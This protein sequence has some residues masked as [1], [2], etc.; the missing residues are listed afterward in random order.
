MRYQ[1]RKDDECEERSFLF[2]VKS[3]FALVPTR[4]PLNGREDRLQKN[5]KIRAWSCR[6]HHDNALQKG[7]AIKLNSVE[8]KIVRT[9]AKH[10]IKGV[11]P[12]GYQLL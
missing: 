12:W 8:I 2:T 11:F 5:V 10:T 9:E 4:P 7:K 3:L 1:Q 6:I